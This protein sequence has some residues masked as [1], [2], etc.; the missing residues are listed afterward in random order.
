MHLELLYTAVLWMIFFLPIYPLPFPLVPCPASAFFAL[1]CHILTYPSLYPAPPYL[2]LSS[3][4][5][6]CPTVP[7]VPLPV[8]CVLLWPASG[9]VVTYTTLTTCSEGQGKYLT[10]REGHLL[11]AKWENIYFF[12]LQHSNS[13]RHHILRHNLFLVVVWRNQ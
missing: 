9:A 11:S 6:A 8:L 5:L 12:R 1:H 2:V 10:P 4:L 7:W 13:P 3:L